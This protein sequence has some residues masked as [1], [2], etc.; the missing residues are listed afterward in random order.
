[1]IPILLVRISKT[2]NTV[3]IIAEPHTD[4]NTFFLVPNN[5]DIN[6][7]ETKLLTQYFLAHA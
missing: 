1:M 4:W 5:D 2:N 6:F 7:I 3:N